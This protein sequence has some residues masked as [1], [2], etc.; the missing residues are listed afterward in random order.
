M[1]ELDFELNL[2]GDKQSFFHQVDALDDLRREDIHE[3]SEES[4]ASALL[5][6]YL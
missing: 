2:A 3:E 6:E 1:Q 5:S 4:V